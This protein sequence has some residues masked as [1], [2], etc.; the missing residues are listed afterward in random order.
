M[1]ATEAVPLRRASGDRGQAAEHR[2]E[3][4]AKGCPG[5]FRVGRAGDDAARQ[6]GHAADQLGQLH[7]VQLDQVAVRHRRGDERPQ[8]LHAGLLGRSGLGLGVEAHDGGPVD[9]DD[10]PELRVERSVQVR[11]HHRRDLVNRLRSGPRPQAPGLDD[12]VLRV[13]PGLRVDGA[14]QRLLVGEVVVHR[15]LGDPGRVRD[16]V[17]RRLRVAVPAEQRA[18]RG[19]HGATGGLG[20]LGPEPAGR[21]GAAC[22]SYRSPGHGVSMPAV[23]VNY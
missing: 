13:G 5:R 23:E 19:E 20:V 14:E 9:Q 21:L 17:H 22:A 4:A 1:A 10:P 8:R 16:L 2:V 12:A 15:A 18:G 7:G 3:G 11:A 6:P